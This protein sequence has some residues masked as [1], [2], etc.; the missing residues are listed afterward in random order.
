MYR[1]E[2]FAFGGFLRHNTEFRLVLETIYNKEGNFHTE[3]FLTSGKKGTCI[4][5]FCA[6][7]SFSHEASPAHSAEV[8]ARLRSLTAPNAV[9]ALLLSVQIR[10]VAFP[11]ASSSPQQILHDGKS[12]CQHGSLSFRNVLACTFLLLILLNRDPN[13][14][15]LSL[16]SLN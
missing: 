2:D 10:V 6:I 11:L 8:C 4:L 9:C 7:F 13:E 12:R 15:F 14:V 3:H 16:L 1:Q 5:M